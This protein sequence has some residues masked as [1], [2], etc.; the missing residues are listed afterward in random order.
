MGKLA[1]WR[2]VDCML[3]CVPVQR[4][5]WLQYVELLRERVAV[6][7]VHAHIF[8]PPIAPYLTDDFLRRAEQILDEAE[9]LVD[10]D[11]RR[12][13]VQMARLPIW[14]VQLATNRVTGDAK[15]DLLRR[16]LS[17]ARKAGI[18]NISEGRSLNDWA[19]RMGAE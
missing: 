18:T 14:Y 1:S 9:G 2:T 11:T 8:D 13:R 17:I 19:K 6:K 5:A 7:N 16:F 12:F 3:T 15:A 10:N 4:I